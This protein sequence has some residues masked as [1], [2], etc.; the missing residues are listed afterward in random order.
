MVCNRAGTWRRGADGRVEPVNQL[1][2]HGE[3][4]PPVNDSLHNFLL[5]CCDGQEG[6][7]RRGVCPPCRDEDVLGGEACQIVLLPT[8]RLKLALL[9]LRVRATIRILNP[10]N[11]SLFPFSNFLVRPPYVDLTFLPALFPLPDLM[12][13]TS[14]GLASLGRVPRL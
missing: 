13:R 12:S 4:Q 14:L 10:E 7:G 6:C 1:Q 8:R 3:G 5:T 2:V 9:G 11:I